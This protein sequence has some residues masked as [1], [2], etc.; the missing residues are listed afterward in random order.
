MLK[1]EEEGLITIDIHIENVE[2]TG[3]YQAV[4]SCLRAND[5]GEVATAWNSIRREIGHDLVTKHLVPAAAK[6]VKEHL[7]SESE[8][9]VADFCRQTLEYVSERVNQAD[10]S[11]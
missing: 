7:R 3:F 2:R 6:W 9:Y 4:E 11:E 5:F 10:S 8:D 1:A